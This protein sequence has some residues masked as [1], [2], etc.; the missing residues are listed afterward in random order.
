MGQRRRPSWTLR[1]AVTV[2]QD[3]AH[4]LLFRSQTR[5]QSAGPRLWRGKEKFRLTSGCCTRLWLPPAARRRGIA[6]SAPLPPP[7]LTPLH[8]CLRPSAASC[9]STPPLSPPQ[10]LPSTSP[11]HAPAPLPQ[12]SAPQSPRPC[13]AASGLRAF[14]PAQTSSGILSEPK[15]S[16]KT[17]NHEKGEN[18]HGRTDR[19]SR[20]ALFAQDR[21]VVCRRQP[22]QNAAVERERIRGCAHGAHSQ[23][24][25]GAAERLRPRRLVQP[26]R[27]PH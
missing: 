22:H 10:A 16:S 4:G 18:T 14:A 6:P 26:L 1:L 8:R 15:R 2:G 20:H 19:T 27:R 24:Q 3:G 9:A 23:H 11:P 25:R 7:P 5:S 12:A 21:P 17:W 13:T